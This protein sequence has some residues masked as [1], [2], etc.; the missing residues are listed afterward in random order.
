[1]VVEWPQRGDRSDAAIVAVDEARVGDTWHPADARVRVDLPVAPVVWR[2]D[3]LELYGSFR[4]TE[5]VELRGFRDWLEHRG[6]HGVFRANASRVLAQGGREDVGSR[7]Y[8]LLGHVEE[9]LRRHIPGAEGA[10]A[11]GIL[12]GD[13]GLL[14]KET[15]EA[16]DATSTSHTMALS[17]WNIAIIAWLCAWIGRLFRRSR[18]ILWLCGSTVAIWI[19][20]VF[21]GPS[22]TLLRAAIMGTACLAAEVVGRRSDTLTALSLSAVLLT[23]HDPA[24]LLDIGFQLSCA[25]TTGLILVAPGLTDWLSGRR[26]P[27]VIALAAATTVAAEI[28]TLPLVLHHFGRVSRLTLPANL[29]VEPLVPAIMGAAFVTALAS[30]IPGPLVDLVGYAAW[31]PARL[32]LLAVETLGALPWATQTFP[33]TT[34]PITFVLYGVIAVAVSGPRW[35][36]PLQASIRALPSAR[37]ALDPIGVGLLGGLSLGAWLLLLLG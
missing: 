36:P 18:S 8:A 26:V 6:L 19:F 32:M 30:F 1:V 28:A 9:R 16:F 10:L 29:L 5:R 37:P 7:R 20:V 33:A 34:W 25:A 21:V 11:T 27:K 24:A 22:P 17:G 14:P 12:L 2:S 4:P 31:I 23:A 13:D 35:F 3:I 15:R